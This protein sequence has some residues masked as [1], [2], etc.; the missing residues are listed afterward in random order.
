MLPAIQETLKKESVPQCSNIKVIQTE[1][2]YEAAL[3]GAATVCLNALENQIRATKNLKNG[4]A[5]KPVTQKKPTSKN[6]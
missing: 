4:R 1:L 5:I 3:L 2:G 6:Y